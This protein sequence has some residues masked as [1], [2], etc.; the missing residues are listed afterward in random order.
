MET[1][2]PTLTEINAEKAR[3]KIIISPA[4]G[5]KLLEMPRK[6]VGETPTTPLTDEQRATVVA[7]V[8]AAFTEAAGEQAE[9]FLPI[10]DQRL[11]ICET[12]PDLQDD[13]CARC[14]SCQNHWPNLMNKVVQ[15]L[16]EEHIN[17][18]IPTGGPMPMRGQRPIGAPP[19]NAP[20]GVGFVYKATYKL[21]GEDRWMLVAT[22][23]VGRLA[24]IIA[25]QLPGADFS[26]SQKL[27]MIDAVYA[28][29]GK[30]TA[31]QPTR[32]Y[33]ASYT[34]AGSVAV[35]HLRTLAA[36]IGSLVA[37]VK[38]HAADAK[39]HDATSNGE[40][41]YVDGNLLQ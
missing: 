2:L 15:G 35:K 40:I 12:C 39:M 24:E 1:N 27:T 19:E 21:D 33:N 29:E 9:S 17:R 32:A 10:I 7:K 14:N 23:D 6:K 28:A 16:C 31:G 30:L 37:V 38:A 36:D 26:A 25:E 18:G 5:E 34:L 3:G 11:A 20:K 13:G 8:R 41:H 22:T 4:L